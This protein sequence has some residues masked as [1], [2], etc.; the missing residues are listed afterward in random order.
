MDKIIN[1]CFPIMIVYI[2]KS[3]NINLGDGTG[4][5]IGTGT[6]IR[7]TDVTKSSTHYSRN[8]I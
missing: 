5:G 4:I 6:G 7:V 8:I 1:I 2:I 3:N